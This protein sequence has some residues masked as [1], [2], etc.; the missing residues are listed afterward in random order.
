MQLFRRMVDVT[1]LIDHTL[2][3]K[4]KKEKTPAILIP[5]ERIRANEMCEP[6]PPREQLKRYDVI[7][8]T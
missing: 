1:G 5:E 3:P 4:K 7:S 6:I 8:R 2:Y